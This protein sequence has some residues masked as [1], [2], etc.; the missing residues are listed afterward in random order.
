MSNCEA[1]REEIESKI[2]QFEPYLSTFRKKLVK[3][4]YVVL[5]KLVY[6]IKNTKNATI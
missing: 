5:K 4:K 1:S 3:N 6:V 2:D